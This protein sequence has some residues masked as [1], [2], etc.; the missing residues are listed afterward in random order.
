MMPNELNAKSPQFV[1]ATAIASGYEHCVAILR[2]GS[3]VAWGGVNDKGQLDIPAEVRTKKAVAIAAQDAYWLVH[4]EDGAVMT[5]GG[6]SADD[7]MTVPDT[8]MPGTV[9]EVRRP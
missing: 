8:L 6:G 7:N 5:L 3:V 2:N 1:G 4:F 9:K